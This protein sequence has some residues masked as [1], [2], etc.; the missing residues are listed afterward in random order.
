MA[1]Q[2]HL[3]VS[4]KASTKL[5]YAALTNWQLLTEWFCD[6][7]SVSARPGGYFFAAWNR[8]FQAVGKFTAVE[9]NKRLALSVR[10]SDEASDGQIELTLAERGSST[11]V[12]LRHDY[13]S[14]A[15]KRIW[16]RGLENLQSYLETGYDLR[17]T[18]RPMIGIAPAELDAEAAAKLGVPVSKGTHITAL[19]PNMSAEKAGLKPNDV[20]VEL[21]GKSVTDYVSMTNAVGDHQAGDVVNVVYYRGAE[22]HQLQLAFMPRPVDPIP[23]SAQEFAA[24]LETLHAELDTEIRKVF[25]GISEELTTRRPEPTE[26]SARETVIHLLALQRGFVEIIAN[27]V[28][29]F[30]VAFPSVNHLAMIGAL[31]ATFASTQ[32]AVNELKRSRDE[33]LALVRAM[34]DE[35]VAQRGA[36]AY[37][38]QNLN[39]VRDHDRTHFEQMRKAIE[40]AREPAAV[41]G[42]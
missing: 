19:V 36:F 16:E 10:G 11:E 23:A 39:S 1:S 31:A 26:W 37:I 15:W 7:A 4:V 6:D 14:E 28:A 35:F 2:I 13:S 12:T 42:D 5:V 18:R 33:T 17:I 20:I 9:E 38:V 8:G 41:I 34:P 24:A 32:D 21:D 29:G 25:A 22:K 30:D 40:A 27:R 3:S